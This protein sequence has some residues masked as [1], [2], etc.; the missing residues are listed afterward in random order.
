MVAPC[1]FPGSML[2]EGGKRNG[3]LVRGDYVCA[4]LRLHASRLY[5]W[6]EPQI[7]AG[8]GTLD[9]FATLLWLDFMCVSSSKTV[10]RSRRIDAAAVR[11]PQNAAVIAGIVSS[12]PQFDWH[13]SAHEQAAAITEHLYQGLVKE[14]P[15]ATCRLK[16]ACFSSASDDLHKQLARSRG[17]L[18]CRKTAP[19]FAYLRCAW[20]VWRGGGVGGCF[21]CVFGGKWLSALRRHIAFDTFQI[22]AL[23]LELRKSCRADKRDYVAKL[24]DDLQTAEHSGVHAAFHK[25]VKLKKRR[26]QGMEPL[27][28]LLKADGELCVTP[29]EI[30]DRWVEHFA[31]LE[32]GVASDV[33]VLVAGCIRAQSER[34]HAIRIDAAELPSLQAMAEAFGAVQSR[35]AA[36]PDL[37]P[38]ELCRSFPFQMATLWWPV[39]LKAFCVGCEAIGL[40]GGMQCRIPKPHGDKALC[41]SSQ[42]VLLQPAVSKAFHRAT[43]KLLSARFGR[44]AL[45]F[46]IGGRHNY[47]ALFGSLCSRSFLRYCGKFGFSGSITFVDLVAAYYAVVREL[48]FGRDAESSSLASIT[49]AMCLEAEDLQ[50]LAHFMDQEPVLRGEGASQFLWA[51][52]R[53]LHGSLCAA[54]IGS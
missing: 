43:R 3:A 24:A 11:D 9:H 4:P 18:R 20:Q 21:M 48:L 14:F 13:C 31:G 22:K 39:A 26:K 16:G 50:M 12:A 27:P 52:T 5:C 19:R 49:E 8:H 28:R 6:V 53:E 44:V 51:V 17:S 15:L 32:H 54:I 47:S 29:S 30:R 42:A 1:T 34:R 10:A 46:Q 25:L 40:K 37:L 33:D 41:S 38:P 7:S 23:A 35:G 45:D 2:G 36:G